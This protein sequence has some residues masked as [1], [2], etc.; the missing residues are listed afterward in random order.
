MCMED[1]AEGLVDFT[2]AIGIR[3]N[4]LSYTQRA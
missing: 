1:W 3:P 4:K 2:K